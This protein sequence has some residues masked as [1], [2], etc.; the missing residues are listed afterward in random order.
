MIQGGWYECGRCGGRTFWQLPYPEDVS[1]DALPRLRND[2]M[3]RTCEAEN[4]RT[5]LTQDE[6]RNAHHLSLRQTEGINTIKIELMDTDT[7]SDI[8]TLAV[9]LFGDLTQDVLAGEEVAINGKRHIMHS[10]GHSRVAYPGL[11]AHNIRYINRE[12]YEPDIKDIERVKRFVKQATEEIDPKT[13][14]AKGRKQ[15]LRQTCIHVR[16]TYHR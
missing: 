13:K 12:T 3:C 6:R 16:A 8:D 1:T 11:Y 7:Y 9:M 4:E 15:H 10:G 2:L 14:A 5:P